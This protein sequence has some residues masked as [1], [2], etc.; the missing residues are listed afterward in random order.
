MKY[1]I[2]LFFLFFSVSLVSQNNK[3]LALLSEVIEGPKTNNFKSFQMDSPKETKI[4]LNSLFLFY[5]NFISSQDSQRCSFHP[6]CSVYG[7]QSIQQKGLVF[8]ALN[9]LDRL[10]R[11]NSLDKQKYTIHPETYLLY[12]PVND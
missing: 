4:I 7:I 3:N 11:C 10:T 1:L 5:K 6:S 9:T 8:G 2:F 12:D